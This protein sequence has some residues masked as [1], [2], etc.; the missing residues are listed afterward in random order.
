LPEPPEPIVVSRM[1]ASAT[2]LV[3]EIC[4]MKN[5]MGRGG[6]ETPSPHRGRGLG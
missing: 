2:V 3:G 1:R 4:Q 6:M 5:T